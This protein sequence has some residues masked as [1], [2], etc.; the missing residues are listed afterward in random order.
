MTISYCGTLIV[1]PKDAEMA[2]GKIKE[3]YRSLISA[4]HSEYLNH[5]HRSDEYEIHIDFS[6]HLSNSGAEELCDKLDNIVNE[7][8]IKATKFRIEWDGDVFYEYKGPN[9]KQ[10]EARDLAEEFLDVADALT[11]EELNVIVN[12]IYTKML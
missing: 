9:A 6:E 7:F 1:S 3:L 4:L 8:S 2:V 12:K 5:N 10:T 11:N